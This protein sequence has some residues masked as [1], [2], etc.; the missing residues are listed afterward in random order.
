MCV[1]TFKICNWR[2]SIK[3]FWRMRI[4][5]D[6]KIKKTKHSNTSHRGACNGEW[7]CFCKNHNQIYWNLVRIRQLLVMMMMTMMLLFVAAPSSCE[8]LWILGWTTFSHKISK[9]FFSLAFWCNQWYCWWCCCRC[10]CCCLLT[11]AV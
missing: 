10:Y 7:R 1:E 2:K 6:L 3:S 5:F 4:N 8:M 11:V 9:Y